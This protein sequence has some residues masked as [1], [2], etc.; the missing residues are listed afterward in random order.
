MSFAALSTGRRLPSINRVAAA[1]SAAVDYFP[2]QVFTHQQQPL[3]P[4]LPQPLPHHL[5]P[6]A[7]QVAAA[8]AAQSR[9][10]MR[11]TSLDATAVTN[12]DR[13]DLADGL[14]LDEADD[15]IVPIFHRP[16]I[17]YPLY[18]RPLAQRTAGG[19]NGCAPSALRY[20]TAVPVPVPV[21]ARRMRLHSTSSEPRAGVLRTGVGYPTDL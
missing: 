21:P 17:D 20:G 11:S 1:A 6:R 2:N 16:P 5:Q 7:A 15:A 3:P 14:P 12:M 13:L 18:S 4:A 19:P 9:I 8:V 10:A